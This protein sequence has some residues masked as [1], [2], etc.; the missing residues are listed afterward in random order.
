MPHL[1]VTKGHGSRN[2]ILVVEG[3]PDTHVPVGDVAET[4]RR[5][6]DRPGPLGSDGVYFLDDRAREPQA[7]FFNPDGSPSLLCGNGMRVAGRMV[8]DRR[9]VDEVII[10]SG[11]YRFT[12][13]RAETSRHGVVHVA[14]SLP[15]VDFAPVPP[16]VAG[17]GEWIGR[18]HPAF[19][20]ERPVTALAV[21]NAHLVAVVGQYDE[22]E[23]VATGRRVSADPEHFP[24]GANVSYV[25][26]LSTADEV[27]IRTYERGAGLSDSCGS[28]VVASR[29]AY[30]RLGALDPGLPLL[31]R[32]PGGPSKV[33]LHTANGRW[34]PT[35]EGNATLVY[36][37]EIDLDLLLHDSKPALF[38]LDAL[39]DEISAFVAFNADNLAALDS[40]GVRF[41]AA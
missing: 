10:R 6:C 19:H 17:G 7:W 28:G 41:A 33:T 12:V 32:N 16:V 26:P 18:A 31:V 13:R 27:F 4:V 25:M 8:L 39:S 35:L 24:Q 40:A 1:S 20:S 15:A 30:A 14:V 9:G 29:A 21:P 2:D 34:Y 36:R 37:A 23:L 11:E 38:D 5:L 22:D 3:A